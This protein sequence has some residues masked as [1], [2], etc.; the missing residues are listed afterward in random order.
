VSADLECARCG[1]AHTA[2]RLQNL[3]PCGG[4]LLVRYDLEAIAG[5]WRPEDLAGRRH[6]LW[7]WRDV[8]PI[9]PDEEALTLG[10]GGTPLLRSRRIGPAI[11]LD[12]LLLKDET[13]NPT[14]S[15]KARG[16]AVAV[17]RARALGA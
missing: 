12:R 15:F 5:R 17:H 11:G 16:M 2:E 7:R 9:G 10:E 4:P 3:C 13:Q 6:D 8:L 1:R 14:G